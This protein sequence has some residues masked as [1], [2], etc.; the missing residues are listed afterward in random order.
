MEGSTPISR[1]EWL[2]AQDYV[3]LKLIED[4][5]RAVLEFSPTNHHEAATILA[6]ATS[7][8]QADC[9]PET[10]DKAHDATKRVAAFLGGGAPSVRSYYGCAVMQE[11]LV[12]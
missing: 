6:V 4:V 2:L 8:C 5:E 1:L 3:P 11:A 12:S 10:R 9:D 7:W